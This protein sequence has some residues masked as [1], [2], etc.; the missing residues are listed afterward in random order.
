MVLKPHG[1]PYHPLGVQ[2]HQFHILSKEIIPKVEL[3]ILLEWKGPLEAVQVGL[4]LNWLYRVS[5]YG[6]NIYEVGH[7]WGYDDI[8]ILVNL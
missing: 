7:I 2:I 5:L 6:R 1:Q 3:K 4:E 8:G